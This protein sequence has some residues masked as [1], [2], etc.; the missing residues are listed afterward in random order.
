MRKHFLTAILMTLLTVT[1][2]FAEQGETALGADEFLSS[3]NPQMG[4]IS[5]PNDVATLDVPE[6]FRYIGPEDTK[7]FLEDGWGNPD[8]SG[9]LGMLLPVDVDLFG[10]EGWGVVI[11]YQ[12][13]GYVSD[14]DAGK[15]D[16]DELMKSMKETEREANEERNKLGYE[17]VFLVGWA[18]PPHYD[19]QAKKLYWAKELKFGGE[20]KNT[21]NYNVRILGRKGVLVMNAVSGMEQL[22]G[23]QEGMKKVIAFTEFTK[24]NQYGDFDP[25]IDK[26]AAY[27]IGALIGGKVA[28][29]VGLFAKF[30]ALLLAFKKF[31]FVALA[32][33]GAFLAKLF[34]RRKIVADPP[35]IPEPPEV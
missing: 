8:G 17:P 22:P 10:P 34:K 3:L 26:V 24:G 7:R 35:T 6:E 2:A 12:E 30:G 5:L 25:G 14:E 4:S 33:I 27:G 16:Y 1:A 11:T 28:A 19:S 29:K 9:T 21:L 31:I 20:E 15:I 23:I 32:A 13:D 18:S